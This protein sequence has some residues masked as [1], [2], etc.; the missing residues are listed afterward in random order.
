MSPTAAWITVVV[1]YFLPLAHV[2]VSPSGGPWRPPSG[3]RC[4]LGPRVGWIVLVLLL[5]P[6]GW[7]LFMH[8][9]RRRRPTPAGRAT[10]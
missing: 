9:H 5:G 2:A 1:G 6:L 3:A 4:P 10:P 8:A 7:L